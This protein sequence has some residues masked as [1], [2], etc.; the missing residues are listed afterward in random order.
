MGTVDARFFPDQLPESGWT[1]L[2]WFRLRLLI[3]PMMR[4]K[5]VALTIY[6]AGASE[7]FVNGQFQF[8]VGTVGVLPSQEIAH[9]ESSPKVVLLPDTE[10]VVLALR[11]SNLTA[12]YLRYLGLP[13]GFSVVLNDVNTRILDRAMQ[14]RSDTGYQM[15]FTGVP[16]AFA[17]IHFFV[18]AFYP[19]TK[20]NL[21]FAVLTFSIAVFIFSNFQGRFLTDAPLQRA[22]M[23]HGRSSPQIALILVLWRFAV[24]SMVVSGARFLYSLFDDGV[25]RRFWWFLAVGGFSA[26]WSSY[27]PLGSWDYF[28]ILVLV[29]VAEIVRTIVWAVFERKEGAVI[30]AAGSAVLMIGALYLVLRNLGLIPDLG[31]HQLFYFG[32]LGLLI[33]MSLLLSKRFAATSVRLESELKTTQELLVANT[34]LRQSGALDQLRAAAA[35]MR[36]SQDISHVVGAL[37]QGLAACNIQI[38]ALH[39]TV[40]ESG[41]RNLQIYAAARVD[42]SLVKTLQDTSLYL[43]Q[44]NVVDGVWL[45]RRTLPISMVRTLKPQEGLH[46]ADTNFYAYLEKAWGSVEPARYLDQR[47]IIEVGFDH[48]C[49]GVI[50]LEGTTFED[51]HHQITQEFGK[52]I[53]LGYARFFDLQR[54][55]VQNKR[56]QQDRAVERIRAR[57]QSMESAADFESVLQVLADDVRGVGMDFR[58]CGIDVLDN[59]VDQP[60]LAVFEENGFR[61]STYTIAGDGQVEQSNHNLTSPFPEVVGDTIARFVE[62]EPWQALIE[63]QTAIVEVPI[64]SFGRLRITTTGR[65]E[66]TQDEINTLKAFGTAIALG[67]ARFL[68]LKALDEARKQLMDEMEQELQ[69][70]REMQMGLMPAG[71]PNVAGFDVSA[72]CLPANHVCGDFYHYFEPDEDRLVVTMADVTGHAMKAAIPGVMFSGILKSQMER[73]GSVEDLV[74]RLNRSLWDTIPKRTLISFLVGELDVSSGK[75]TLSDCGCPYPYHYHAGTG[76]LTEITLS[77]YPLGVGR[78][79]L[80]AVAE[81]QLSAGDYMVFCSDGIPE[82]ERDG[83]LLGYERTSEMILQACGERVGASEVIQRVMTEAIRFRGDQP[84]EDDMTC[85]VIRAVA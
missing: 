25:P 30:I 75:M 12:D 33:S 1:G 13:I 62:G 70:A 49:L 36:S 26:I 81:V 45:W 43:E 14:I 79:L 83:G 21:F 31:I 24:I 50:A 5:P 44:R 10:E 4:E 40:A 8:A 71:H 76:Q 29:V 37:W 32:L 42:G 52:A 41:R 7:I 66:Y 23:T 20:E 64:S 63:G 38:E 59:P 19:R 60:S 22:V 16:L 51:T 61:Y 15:F 72:Q 55:E 68:D 3:P 28:N 74:I 18:F 77:S 85:V 58:T 69:D 53:A 80:P 65:K 48:G 6:H 54:V 11:Y 78:E 57:V 56:L 17:L 67:Y 39:V 82:T 27:D 46:T 9:W 73:G 34:E 47:A 35:D 84:Q 2:G